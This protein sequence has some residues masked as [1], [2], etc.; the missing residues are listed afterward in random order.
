MTT[1]SGRTP[2]RCAA[3]L[4][5]ALLGGFLVTAMSALSAD[6]AKNLSHVG[7]ITLTLSPQEGPPGTIVHVEGS[8]YSGGCDYNDGEDDG[9]N[10]RYKLSWDGSEVLTPTEAT[11]QGGKFSADIRV[12]ATSAGGRHLLVAECGVGEE[13][14]DADFYVSPALKLT[15]DRGRSDAR[16]TVEGSGYRVCVDCD[17]DFQSSPVEVIWGGADEVIATAVM[18]DDGKFRVD[19]VHVPQTAKPGNYQVVGRFGAGEG[20]Q[21]PEATFVVLPS[22]TLTLYP[23]NGLAGKPFRAEGDGYSPC[24]TDVCPPVEVFWG[25]NN[26]KI[27]AGVIGS[28]GKF[29]VN[30]NV[31]QAATPGNH[32][33]VGKS[34][35]ESA[36]ATFSVVPPPVLFLSPNQGRTGGLF[37]VKGSG[38]G[39]CTGTCSYF[40]GPSRSRVEVIWGANNEVLATQTMGGDGTFSVDVR[41]PQTAVPGNGYQ[42]IGQFGAERATG[43]FTVEP[44]PVDPSVLDLTLIPDEGNPGD[45]FKIE[46]SGYNK[47]PDRGNRGVNIYDRNIEGSS[48]FG[49]ELA[50]NVPISDEGKISWTVQMPPTAKSGSHEINGRCFGGADYASEIFTVTGP[51]PGSNGPTSGPPLP[52]FPLPPDPTGPTSSPGPTSPP[53]PPGPTGE[54]LDRAYMATQMSSPIDV[55]DDPLQLL[56]SLLLVGLLVLVVAF[57]ADLFNSTFENNRD[58]INGWFSWVP[59]LRLDLPSW[60]HL[61]ILGLVAAFLLLMAVVRDVG[62]DYATLAQAVGFLI[63]VPLV[64]VALEATRG[65]Y[66]RRKNSIQT[67]FSTQVQRRQ[68]RWRVLPAALIVAGFLALVSRLADFEPPYVYG[69]IAVYIGADLALN[70]RDADGDKGRGTLIG[71]L[72]LFAVSIIAWFSWIPVDSVIDSGQRGFGWLVLDAVLATFFLL[73]LETAVFGMIPLTFLKGKDIFQWRPVIW[74]VVFVPIVYVFINVYIVALIGDSLMLAKMVEDPWQIIKSIML[75]LAFGVFSVLFWG[76]FHPRFR[77]VRRWYSRLVHQ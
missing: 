3:V 12:P 30:V 65:W 14:A 56:L 43:T 69:L 26:E 5:L 33:V 15:P 72:F 44:P 40:P 17:H 60:V 63:A 62:L 23:G 52:E 10:F 28:D 70:N 37:T 39:R 34:G 18:D 59:R 41:V 49:F 54:K 19:D 45:S 57:P 75:F 2:A 53:G 7:P 71:I 35:T 77:P 51:P 22:P 9:P 67:H 24:A 47:C 61:D 4:L 11:S 55:F 21:R 66:Y 76:Y 64:V 27:G 13:G 46:G 68:S 6:D 8:G 50:R 58:E 16:F 1:A 42:V 73:G 25:A 29:S 48:G 74:I 36:V 20:T 31:P 32:Q 38:Y